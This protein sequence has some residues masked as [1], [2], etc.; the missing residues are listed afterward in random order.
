[1]NTGGGVVGGGGI[2]VASTGRGGMVRRGFGRVA[3]SVGMVVYAVG[4]PER[5]ELAE[6]GG[7]EGR[8]ASWGGKE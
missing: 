5:D 7:G 4:E 2:E 8:G 6:F 1:M 3:M